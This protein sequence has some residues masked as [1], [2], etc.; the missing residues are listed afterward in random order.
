MAQAD[1]KIQAFE[2]V[3]F[4]L[5]EWYKE[6]NPSAKNNDISV[7]KALKLLFFVSAVGTVKDS[8]NTLLDSPFNNFVAMPYGHV[9]SDIYA[10]IKSETQFQN[11]SIN[12]E[13]TKLEDIESI[14][15]FKFESKR[16]VDNS[17][18]KLKS[19]NK[20]LVNLSSFELVELSHRWFSWQ[21]NYQIAKES[22]RFSSP[23]ETSEIKSEDKIYQL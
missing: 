7:L 13:D 8:K 1:I 19:I 14:I 5:D 12:S 21:K 9:E 16:N 2:Y 17:I 10:A 18:E 23:I 4:K 20:N 3:L 6:I 11:V 22:G 15:N